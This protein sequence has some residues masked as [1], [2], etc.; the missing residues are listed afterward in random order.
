[1]RVRHP[2]TA[3]WAWFH[4]HANGPRER[5]VIAAASTCPS[6]VPQWRA[7]VLRGLEAWDFSHT[8]SLA[9]TGN[10]RTIAAQG[11]LLALDN[12][13]NYHTIT[14]QSRVW[15]SKT[16]IN[17]RA[18]IVAPLALDNTGIPLR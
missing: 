18:A 4:R 11:A 17:A 6:G 16:A 13:G 15:R 14:A 1:M 3:V 5:V 10:Y 7:S 9:N 2:N 8:R 12:A